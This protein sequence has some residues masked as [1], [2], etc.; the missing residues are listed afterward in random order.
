MKKSY[1]ED[2]FKVIETKIR[3]RKVEME[4]DELGGPT[5][6]LGDQRKPE[7]ILRELRAK[8]RSL[9]SKVCCMIAIINHS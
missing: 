5:F 8:E 3:I 6:R 4:D 7:A 1:L 9:S 2:Q